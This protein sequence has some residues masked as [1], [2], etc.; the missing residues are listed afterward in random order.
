M[1]Q[2][3]GAAAIV[4]GQ[5][6]TNEQIAQHY[7][8]TMIALGTQDMPGT[9]TEINQRIVSSLVYA[10]VSTET[11]TRLG[12]NV[13]DAEV[14]S[15]Y[16]SLVTQYGSIEGLEAAAAAGAV[17]PELIRTILHTSGNFDMLGKKLAPNGTTDEQA[18]AAIAELSKVGKELGIE[19]NP[20][21][22]TWDFKVFG[23]TDDIS[24]SM[25]LEQM[26]P[27]VAAQ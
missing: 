13:T 2:T 16:Q 14:E 11:A 3:P 18:A 8:N 9:A 25:T 26:F 22:G 12:V 6:I 27:P 10:I 15:Q 4:D 24:L 19:I 20:R 23:I 17:P 21:F 1:T 5:R 7:T